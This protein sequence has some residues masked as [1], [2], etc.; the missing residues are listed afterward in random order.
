[1]KNL[2]RTVASIAVLSVSMSTAY[3]EGF[4]YNYI[5]GSYQDTDQSGVDVEAM[6]LSGSFAVAPDLNIVAAYS[7]DDVTTADNTSDITVDTIEL[8]LSYHA[9]INAKTDLTTHVIVVYKDTDTALADDT[10]YA[11]GFGVR[12]QVSDIVEIGANISYEDIYDADDTTYELNARFTVNK[13]VS[14]GL[15]ASTSDE[16]VDT[17]SAHVRYDF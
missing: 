9:P 1:M 2:V 6:S 5:E 16:N 13:S 10:G 3:A 11:L 14:L 8:G 15:T 17:V 4:N 7:I 12:H